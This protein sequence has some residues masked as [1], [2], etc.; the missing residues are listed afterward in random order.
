MGRWY[1]SEYTSCPHC[2]A[3]QEDAAHLLHCPDVGRFS[4]F[5]SEVN[6]LTQWLG[7]SHTDPDLARVLQNYLLQRGKE[8]LSL[9]QYLPQEF[10]PF[11]FEG[12]DRLMLGQVSGQLRH[13]QY[14]HLLNAKSVMSVDDWISVLSA[15]CY[16]LLMVSGSNAFDALSG[17]NCF[18]N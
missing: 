9:A 3:Q 4:P 16:I 11:A 15:S 10:R 7:A 8:A 13:I 2:N 18:Y 1:H 5:R 17:G 14:S 12:W 6:K